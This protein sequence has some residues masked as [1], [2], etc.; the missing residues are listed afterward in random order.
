MYPLPDQLLNRS[1]D[2]GIEVKGNKVGPSRLIAKEKGKTNVLNA[3]KLKKIEPVEDP[4]VIPIGKRTIEEKEGRSPPSPN[5]KKGKSHKD[6]DAKAK[7]KRRA[8]KRI[9]VL[10]F[11]LG[12]GQLSYNLKH[13]LTSKKADVTFGQLVEMVPKL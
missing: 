3:V 2:F 5:K 8:R 11:P 12:D 6:E 7:R 13:N 9:H 4:M 1:N 10:F